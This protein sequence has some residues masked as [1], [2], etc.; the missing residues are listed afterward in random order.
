MSFEIEG[1]FLPDVHNGRCTRCGREAMSG[2]CSFCDAIRIY[3]ASCGVRI[4]EV[5][6]HRCPNVVLLGASK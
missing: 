6:E 4:R 2:T 1:G 5:L 3:C